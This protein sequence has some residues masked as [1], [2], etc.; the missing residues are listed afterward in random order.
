MEETR[1]AA[2]RPSEADTWLSLGEASRMLGISQGTLRR[3]ADRGQVASFTTPGGHRRFP[4]AVIQ[5][6]LPA[7]RARRPDVSEL[8]T[9]SDR[10]AGVYRQML[11]DEG[12]PIPLLSNLP[13]RERRL[14]RERGRRIVECLVTHLDSEAPAQAIASLHEA[15]GLAA[16]YGAS[17]A[18]LG[19]SLGEAVQTFLPFRAAFIE[20]LATTARRRRLDTREATG[21][22]VDGENAIDHLLISFIEGWQAA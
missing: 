18:R 13:E 16:E 14:H 1:A 7:E 22:L 8:G 12:R 9:F 4:R 2:A 21:L 5:A 11:T 6:L 3:W 15:A 17:T 19:A 10:M 20:Q